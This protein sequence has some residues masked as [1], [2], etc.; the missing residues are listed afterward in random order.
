M[1]DGYIVDGHGDLLADD[2]FCL[3]DGPR[4][5]DCL[6]FDDRLR[7]LDQLDDAAFLAMDLERLDAPEL[8]ARFLGWY[9]EFAG[10]PAPPSLLHHYLAYRAFVRAKVA[11]LRHHQGDPA[12]AGEAR[13]LTG[14]THRHLATAAVTLVLVG[15]L[16]G[17]GKST[18]AGGLADQLGFTLLSSDRIRKELAAVNPDRPAPARYGEGIYTP[19]WTE[20][21]YAE[22]LARAG[23]LLTLGESVVLDAS[24]TDRA[25][26][27]AAADVAARAHSDLT[28]LRCG[29]PAEVAAARMRQRGGVSDA[30]ETH[31]R[32]DARRRPP[33]ARGGRRGHH[34]PA[35]SRRAAGHRPGPA[36]PGGA[37]L[38]APP[39]APRPG[40]SPGPKALFAGTSASARVP[41]GYSR[42]VEVPALGSG[43]VRG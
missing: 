23:R 12:A 28:A 4:V 25:A 2:I 14:I 27:A 36:A 7:Y 33:L 11:C 21:T 38:A 41:R 34:R 42:L 17:T 15:G 9:V 39:P 18:L 8:A 26:R 31:R 10:D 16:P 30:D 6:E 40:L 43:G 24:W 5:L 13:A 20:R 32:R 22:L 37:A 35:R 19:A 1:R 3:P 29:V